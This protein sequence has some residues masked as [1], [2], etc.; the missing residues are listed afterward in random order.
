MRRSASSSS[1]SSPCHLVL[2][3]A[4]SL[5]SRP[6]PCHLPAISYSS[7]PSP[8]HL[9]FLPAISLPSRSASYSLLFPAAL[10]VTTK[11]M[12]PP[13]AGTTAP[14]AQA[15]CVPSATQLAE[16]NATS[17]DVIVACLGELPST[18]KPGDIVD[19][20][21][22]P[23]QAALVR[24]LAARGVPVVLVLIGGRPRLLNGLDTLYA[25]PRPRTRLSTCTST[26]LVRY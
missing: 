10:K 24:A 21:I 8:C 1:L 23:G 18:E 11:P 19:L 16:L 5:P 9:V 12:P 4:I 25:R 2:L 17:A 20:S 13:S 15:S 6:P 22:D 26:L 7:L 14:A 3:P